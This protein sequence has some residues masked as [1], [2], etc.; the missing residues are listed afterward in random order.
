MLYK[1]GY[2]VFKNN[3]ITG[4]GNKNYRIETCE[5]QNK[6]NYVCS[7]HAH[8]VYFDLLSEHGLVGFFIIFFIMYKLIFSKIKKTLSSSNYLQI[9]TLIYLLIT[10]LPILPSGAFFSD[11]VLTIFILNLGI[12]YA[13]G[14]K[15]NIFEKI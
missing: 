11:Y 15:T 12:F 13:S 14:S 4:V 8:Q 10:F 2:Q 6:T 7:T 9:G 3:K 1:S 5:N